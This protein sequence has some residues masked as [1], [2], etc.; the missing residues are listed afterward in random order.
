MWHIS[1]PLGR[2]MDNIYDCKFDFFFFSDNISNPLE[3][4]GGTVDMGCSYLVTAN[5]THNTDY[6]VCLYGFLYFDPNTTANKYNNEI[7]TPCSRCTFYSNFEEMSENR[8]Q[9][10]NCDNRFP[11]TCTSM[12]FTISRIFFYFL[13]HSYT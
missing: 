6:M 9:Q 3:R 10:W 8:G 2:V 5:T 11:H 4:R 13:F 12:F 1:E 7:G